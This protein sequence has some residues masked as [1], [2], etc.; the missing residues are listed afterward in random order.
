MEENRFLLCYSIGRRRHQGYPQLPTKNHPDNAPGQEGAVK[1]DKKKTL[2]KLKH[3]ARSLIADFK[4]ENY[5]HGLDC[6]GQTG[7]L[8]RKWG[9]K[10]LIVSSLQDRD[11]QN[12]KTLADSLARA[13]LQT[14]GHTPTSRPNS[15][16]EDV[17]RIQQAILSANPDVILTASGGSGIDATKAAGV[18]AALGGNLDDYFGAGKVAESAAAL[19]K[20]LLP[21]VAVQT[22]SGSA[23]HLTK[24]SNI[25]DLRTSQKKLIIDEAVVPA[26]SL[27]DYSLT[28]SMSPAFT[29]DGAFDGLS[30]CLEVYYG[31]KPEDFSKIEEIALTGIELILASLEKAVSDPGNKDA[32]EALGLAT[33]LGGYAIMIGG[34]NGAHLT[35]FSLVDVLSHGRACAILNPYYTV[36]F[37][38]AISRQLQK[39]WDL[40]QKYGLAPGDVGDMDSERLGH[41]VAEGLIA[42]GRRVNFPTTLAAIDGFTAGHIARALEAAKDPQLATKLQ[43][44]PVPLTAENVD[45]YMGPVLEA[46][47]TGDFSLIKTFD[48]NDDRITDG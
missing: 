27:F 12:F 14:A 24:Y 33:D 44:M 40:F 23:A 19:D 3:K 15:P 21:F 46:A 4:Q 34:T 31:A 41:A 11:P 38:P 42:L 9:R 7:S 36:F 28:R 20:R 47:R 25:T 45:H 39:L 26:G 8:V 2:E 30:H 35:S 29:C 48:A 16:Q 22:A 10:V 5:I 6:I 13:G 32:R 17:F 1:L 43:N 37:A 18:L